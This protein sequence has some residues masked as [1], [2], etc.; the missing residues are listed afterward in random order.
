MKTI[1]SARAVAV[2]CALAT[3]T[4]MTACSSSD[5]AGNNLHAVSLSF[6]ASAPKSAAAF[7]ASASAVSSTPAVLPA[8]SRVQLVLT[9]IELGRTDSPGCVEDDEDED[10]DVSSASSTPPVKEHE[11]EHVMRDPILVDMP[12]DGS[13]KTQL[14][15]P[16][17]AG[18][19]KQLEAKLEPA[20]SKQSAGAA[21]LA[22]HPEFAGISL[23][24][25]G[26]FNGA[27]FT[28]KTGLR[29]GIHMKF[30]PPLVVDATT[31]NATISVDVSKWFVAA[32]GE[33]IDPTKATPGTSA[34][35]AVEKNIRFSFHA[36]ED[37]EKH[38][39]DE[40]TGHKEGSGHK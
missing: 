39:K 12:V 30:N 37:N 14:S 38:G 24:V 34:S 21:F 27:P 40:G 5:L 11:C 16:L 7:D 13:L 31:R 17:A 22:A 4:A 1:S 10:D 18:T 28:Y 23:K 20:S 8:I 15:V 9:K 6:T 32:S 19:Y 3:G 2:F 36:F 26:T 35:R 25:D 33:V 29:A